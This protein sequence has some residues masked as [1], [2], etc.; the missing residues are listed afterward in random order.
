MVG[1]RKRKESEGFQKNEGT[2][3]IER[4]SVEIKRLQRGMETLGEQ[5]RVAEGRLRQKVPTEATGIPHGPRTCGDIR[6]CTDD[7]SEEGPDCIHTSTLC[8]LLQQGVENQTHLHLQNK[9][10]LGTDI[11]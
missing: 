7:E 5:E 9:H 1:I 8:L 6:R 2:E 11:I 10:F 4:E 3:G